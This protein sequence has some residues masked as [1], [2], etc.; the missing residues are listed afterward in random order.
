MP[1]PKV[2]PLGIGTTKAD[3][4]VVDA[5]GD[6][7]RFPVG[8]DG[9]I[10]VADSTQP[11]GL[12]WISVTTRPTIMANGVDA[13]FKRITIG[14]LI[15]LPASVTRG[16]FSV[17]AYDDA[18]IQGLAW[19]KTMPVSYTNGNNIKVTIYWVSKTAVVGDVIWACA[20]ERDNAA[21]H[22]IDTDAFAA[23][24]TAAASTAPAASGVIQSVSITLTQAQ[25]DGLSAGDPFRIFVQRTANAVGDTMVGDAQIVDVVIEGL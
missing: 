6:L 10:I 13:I 3:L 25:A 17:I 16:T 14:G 20:F 15:A 21:N 12:R 4:Y 23:L 2:G 22:D 1:T 7:E 24:Q 18:V 11:L 9:Q 8:T 19:Q 5:N